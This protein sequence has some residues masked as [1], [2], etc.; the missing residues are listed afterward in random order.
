MTIT[1]SQI[2]GLYLVTLGVF[3]L[4]IVIGFLV[5]KSNREKP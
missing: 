3:A 1:N 2:V 5:G 4:G